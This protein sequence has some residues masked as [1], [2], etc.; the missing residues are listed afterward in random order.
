M[1]R[2][3][4]SDIHGCEKTFKALLAK[5][6]FSK[7][8]EL[9]LLG[10]YI[11]RG[12]DSRGVIDHIWKLQEEGFQV[13][14]LRG[15]HEQMLLDEV[16]NIDI[17]YKGEAATLKSFGVEYNSDIPPK[18]I[19]WMR[20]LEYYFELEDYILVHAGLNFL[21]SDPLADLNGMMWVRDWYKFINYEWLE[22]RKI[23]H[24]H[25]PTI[26]SKIEEHLKVIDHLPVLVIDAGCC[27]VGEEEFGNLCAFNLETRELVFQSNVESIIHTP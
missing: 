9:F 27:Y 1:S 24:G 20:R 5:I 12:P 16:D 14:C 7:E 4:I 10:D 6:N 26:K 11:D 18:Y 23:I 19:E 21:R 8:D 13:N 17:W 2:Y 3:A 22:K 25:T 15:N